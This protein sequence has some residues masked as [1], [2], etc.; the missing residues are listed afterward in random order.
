M[1]AA[2]LFGIFW[3]VLAVSLESCTKDKVDAVPLEILCPDTI[4]YQS[5]IVPLITLNCSVTDCHDATAS[6]GLNMTNY[7]TVSDNAAK[8]LQAMKHEAGVIP[9]PLDAEPIA[10]SLILQF[11]CWYRRGALEN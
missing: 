4:S 2:F 3:I 9:M 10:D 6:G 7:Q 1:K 5:Q 8:M 11:E